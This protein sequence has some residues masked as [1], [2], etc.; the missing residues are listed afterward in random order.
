MPAR[1]AK[2]AELRIGIRGFCVASLFGF[3][4]LP[5]AFKNL[6]LG[7]RHAFLRNQDRKGDPK[8]KK[9]TLITAMVVLAAGA[10]CAQNGKGPRWQQ[11][12]QQ[13]AGSGNG[14]GCR[15]GPQDGTGPIHQPGTGGGTGIGK[16]KRTGPQDG[17]GP[18]HQPGTGGG[19][20]MGQRRGRK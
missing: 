4:G 5:F 13:G 11:G 14:N 18:I 12:Q 7:A 3:S 2:I 10:T 1:C 9:L 8:M 17:T 15:T 20:G 16:G 6:N 19:A